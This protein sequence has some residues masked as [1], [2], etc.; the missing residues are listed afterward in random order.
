MFVAKTAREKLRAV[1]RRRVLWHLTVSWQGRRVWHR[2]GGCW[3]ERGTDSTL[4][5]LWRGTC[6][7]SCPQLNIRRDRTIRLPLQWWS[8]EGRWGSSFGKTIR[9]RAEASK[10]LRLNILTLIKFSN[11][12]YVCHNNK[13]VPTFDCRNGYSHFNWPHC[14]TGLIQKQFKTF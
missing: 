9:H 6:F 12:T 4:S 11:S 1:T 5:G 13:S 3:E 14:M 2:A 7:G 8:L 10:S